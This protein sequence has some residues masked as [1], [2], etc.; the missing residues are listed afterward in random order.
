MCGWLCC[1]RG[2]VERPGGKL[3]RSWSSHVSAFM[4]CLKAKFSKSLEYFEA[5]FS[6]S[7]GYLK[8]EFSKSVHRSIFTGLSLQEN[9]G[10]IAGLRPLPHATLVPLNPSIL[11]RLVR[12]FSSFSA[13]GRPIKSTRIHGIQF[14]NDNLEA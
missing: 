11:P 5:K 10:G 13:N 2:T 9:P 12:V 6:K 1:G 4:E 7:L 14:F 8:A 3:S